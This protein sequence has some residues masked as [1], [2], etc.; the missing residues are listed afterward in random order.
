[1]GLPPHILM[2]CWAQ[3]L[4]PD[5]M[6]WLCHTSIVWPLSGAQKIPLYC[7]DYNW[8]TTLWCITSGKGW[9]QL[10]CKHLGQTAMAIAWA[11]A[12]APACIAG[13]TSKGG[14]SKDVIVL[15]VLVLG[16]GVKINNNYS[17]HFSTSAT[18]MFPTCKPITS[19]VMMCIFSHVPERN[20]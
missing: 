16:R 8:P 2:R 9:Q 14:D 10:Y 18:I 3:H 15:V 12:P 19:F 5:S 11:S 7:T 13:I 4:R 1:M 6:V 20:I 17:W